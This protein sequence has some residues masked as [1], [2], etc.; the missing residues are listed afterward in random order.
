MEASVVPG[1]AE[2]FRA[3][4]TLFGRSKTAGRTFHKA[5]QQGKGTGTFK[6]VLR[7]KGKTILV[8]SSY[9]N[10]TNILT[11]NVFPTLNMNNEG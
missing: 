10:V 8:L 4:M 1:N 11:E 9:V 5:R 7:V 3:A 6:I 2:A